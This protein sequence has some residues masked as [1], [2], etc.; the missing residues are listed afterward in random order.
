MSRNVDGRLLTCVGRYTKDPSEWWLPSQ[1]GRSL[2]ARWT[3]AFYNNNKHLYLTTGAPRFISDAEQSYMT[4]LRFM[5]YCQGGYIQ[6]VEF[7]HLGHLNGLAGGK[8]QVEIKISGLTFL[9][10]IEPHCFIWVRES[11]KFVSVYHDKKARYLTK[12]THRW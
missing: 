11:E 2:P 3:V 4:F 10:A 1:T 6:D 7:R 12:L 9:Q 8:A 5:D